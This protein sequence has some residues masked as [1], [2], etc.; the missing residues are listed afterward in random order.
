M[1][2]C[3]NCG[4]ELKSTNKF[5][6][7]CGTKITEDIAKNEGQFQNIKDSLKDKF[8]KEKWSLKGQELSQKVQ[9]FTKGGY[10]KLDRKKLIG[11][12]TIIV[13]VFAIIFSSLG[14]RTL[15]KVI[16]GH[17]YYV[18]SMNKYIAFGKGKYADHMIITDSKDVVLNALESEARFARVYAA[19]N[20]DVSKDVGIG[21]E[22]YK[23]TSDQLILTAKQSYIPNDDHFANNNTAVVTDFW[24]GLATSIFA[25]I[26]ESGIN[27]TINSNNMQIAD[28]RMDFTNVKIS[29]WG[30]YKLTGTLTIDG[31]TQKTTFEEVKR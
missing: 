2:F 6:P 5:C 10:K 21:V 9:E 22:Q 14:A 19:T 11:I 3:P 20:I 16:P 23:V 17:A 18:T 28:I 4:N 15:P 7:K 25:P 13:L 31:K 27:D 8:P 26:I 29:G 12:G 24:G 1:K 30:K